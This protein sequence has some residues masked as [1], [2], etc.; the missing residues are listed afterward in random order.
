M[1]RFF[2]HSDKR[3]VFR[4]CINSI[5]KTIDTIVTPEPLVKCGVSASEPQLH[6]V[7]MFGTR[8]VGMYLY[9]DCFQEIAW[10]YTCHPS[11]YSDM[12]G[13]LTFQVPMTALTKVNVILH[14]VHWDSACHSF[15]PP[16]L[17]I[18]FSAVRQLIVLLNTNATGRGAGG[19]WGQ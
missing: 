9:R 17:P 15:C 19:I 10:Y 2:A 16:L 14:I 11:Q 18:S 1:A 4:P 12:V 5:I 6:T 3:D 8:L 7:C 13:L